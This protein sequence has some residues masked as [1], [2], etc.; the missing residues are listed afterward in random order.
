MNIGYIRCVPIK[1]DG[2]VSSYSRVKARVKRCCPIDSPDPTLCYGAGRYILAG[3][4]NK[5]KRIGKSE[6]TGHA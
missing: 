3:G 5:R 2:R 6:L 4:A 1:G